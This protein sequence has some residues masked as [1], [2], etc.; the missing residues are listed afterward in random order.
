ML[1]LLRMLLALGM[2]SLCLLSHHA[3]PELLLGVDFL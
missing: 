3:S 1:A 2:H